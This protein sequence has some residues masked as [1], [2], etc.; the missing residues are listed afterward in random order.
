MVDKVGAKKA[1]ADAN[2]EYKKGNYSAAV[3]LYTKARE[4]D[5]AEVTYPANRANV[6]LKME[7]WEDAEKDCDDAL[8]MKPKFAKVK[9][10]PATLLTMLGKELYSL[11]V[12]ILFWR[13]T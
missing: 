13:S 11:V 10:N 6:F 9:K 8:K 7:K 2:A 3:E 1:M 12:F 5:P 4:L